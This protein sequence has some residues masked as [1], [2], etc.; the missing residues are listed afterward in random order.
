MLGKQNGRIA[1]KTNDFAVKFGARTLVAIWDVRMTFSSTAR[2]DCI[3]Y[4]WNIWKARQGRPGV[5]GSLTAEFKFKDFRRGMCA[6]IEAT[7]QDNFR[8]LA[9][10]LFP[11][12]V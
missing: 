3:T 6:K 1:R 7:A 4:R 5:R 9:K 11:A 2:A 12:A 8:K 10:T